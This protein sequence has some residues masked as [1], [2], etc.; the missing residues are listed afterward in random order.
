MKYQKLNHKLALNYEI[1]CYFQRYKTFCSRLNFYGTNTTTVQII[2]TNNK[3]NNKYKFVPLVVYF[4]FKQIRLP[5]FH[6]QWKLLFIISTEAY[7]C[8]FEETLRNRFI[9][10]IFPSNF[11]F[12]MLPKPI[13]RRL[14]V[15]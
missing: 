6:L 12:E 10:R 1:S 15:F 13:A 2:S 14:A 5:T 11:I 3:Y 4:I 9:V 8:G 7:S